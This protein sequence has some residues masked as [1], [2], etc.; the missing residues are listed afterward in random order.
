ME[1]SA[2]NQGP[3]V[4]SATARARIAT[5]PSRAT[6][7]KFA[8]AD[9]RDRPDSPSSTTSNPVF[10]SR[11]SQPG[12]GCW[13]GSRNH[14]PQSSSST[15]SS[16]G[17]MVRGLVANPEGDPAQQPTLHD[18]RVS[19]GRLVERVDRRERDLKPNLADRA[20]ERREFLR[21]VL[22]IVR[23]ESDV[24]PLTRHGLDSVRV[25]DAAVHAD[26]VDVSNEPVT[27]GEGEHRIEPVRGELLQPA[28]AVRAA[29]ID[30]RLGPETSDERGGLRVGGRTEHACTS[31]LRE[32]HGEGPDS[33][34]G[35]DDQDALP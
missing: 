32:L 24:R 5:R 7:T 34:G 21:A 19:R 30:H 18:P 22:S 35:P 23:K 16:A 10:N 33:P 14:R 26:E 12:R 29:G 13:H 8:V 11:G 28:N 1:T 4:V 3:R 25:G 6:K 9:R 31:K 15:V 27:T 17:S 2:E 20:D